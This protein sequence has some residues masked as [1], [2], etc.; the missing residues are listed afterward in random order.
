MVRDCTQV[1]VTQDGGI[2]ERGRHEELMGN[3]GWYARMYRLQMGEWGDGMSVRASATGLDLVGGD[4]TMYT[5]LYTSLST[6]R[7][8]R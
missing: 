8:H 6:A 1:L 4:T 7:G 3:G 5:I 2:A